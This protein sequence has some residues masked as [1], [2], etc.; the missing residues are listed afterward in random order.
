MTQ[1]HKQP[2]AA[3]QVVQ[4]FLSYMIGIKNKSR[5]TVYEY[6]VDLR[7]FFIFYLNK[8]FLQKNAAKYDEILQ[9]TDTIDNYI[10][11]YHKMTIADV[12][13]IDRIDIADYLYFLSNRGLSAP[14]RARKLAAIRAYFDY[15][16]YKTYRLEDNPCEM[17]E[18]P[19]FKRKLPVFLTEN[20]CMKLLSTIQSSLD[21]NLERDYLIIALFMFCGLRIDE[22]VGIN[23]GDIHGDLQTG[24]D[25]VLV[26]T[27]KGNKQ[28]TIYLPDICTA[29]Y[30]AY[31]EK[32]ISPKDDKEKALFIS[33]KGMRMSHRAI[34]RMVKKYFA[35]AGLDATR[36]SPHKLRH[37]AATNMLNANT[38]IRIIQQALGHETLQTTQIYTHVSNASLKDAFLNNSLSQA[39]ENHSE[40]HS[41]KNQDK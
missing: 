23:I 38:D 16:C 33:Q 31:T 7:A 40:N 29:A 19:T 34:E 1:Y 15:M 27:G 20:E 35:M 5:N 4:D 25:I 32:R 39:I 30:Y 11:A 17:V 22:L 26:V 37:T 2:V 10:D 12:R 6:S 28:R 9:Q 41:I 21:K 14:T 3:P 18:S 36:L 24:E 8:D 13:N